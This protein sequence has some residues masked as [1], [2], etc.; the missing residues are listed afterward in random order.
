[1]G[2]SIELER[3]E[4][5]I[6]ANYEKVQK[7][8]DKLAPIFEKSLGHIQ[9]T[10]GKTGG[11]VE[12]DLDMEKPTNRLVKQFENM[13]KRV[14]R[15]S[16]NLDKL[17][18]G[19]GE[20]ATK[21]I[22]AGFAK[23][24]QGAT[25]EIDGIA[26]DIKKKMAQARSQQNKAAYLRTQRDSANKKGDTKNVIKFDSQIANAEAAM[27]KYQNAASKLAGGIKA[28][29]KELPNELDK[30]ANKMD[31]NE[32]QIESMRTRMKQLQDQ[33]QNQR[34]SKGGFDTSKGFEDTPQS[35]KTQEL[36]KKQDSKMAEL[37]TKND[38]LAQAYANAE[39]R[40]KQLQA[41][42]GSLNT[43][44]GKSTIQTGNA[45]MGLK[46]VGKGADESKGLFSKFGGLFNRTSN[47]I[48]HGSRRMSN[49]I[50][51][52][53]RRLSQIAKQVLIFALIAKGIRAMSSGLTSALKTNDQFNASV[54]QIKVNLM[55]A[56]YPIYTAILPA[57]NALTSA[58]AKVTGQA[59]H[60]IATLFGT[61]YSAAKQGAQGLYQNINAMNEAGGSAD[62]N[63]EKV[64][65]LQRSL[66]GFDEINRIGLD[67]NKEEKQ[68]GINFNV[69]DVA[70]P[71]WMGKVQKV[72]QDLFKPFQES[73]AKHGKTVTD[74]WKYALKE[75]GGL[76]QSIGRSFME[77]WTNGTGESVLS[78]ILLIVADIGSTVGNLA[79][80]FN[81]AWN[82][83][84]NGTR[85]MQS[86]FNLVN[87]V[88]ET[89][90]KMTSATAEWAR[91]LDFTPLLESIATLMESLEPLTKNIGD[92]L[93]WF[94]KQVL[95]PIASFTIEEV[96]P[97][98]LDVLSGAI[99]ALN[100]V[101]EA[102]KPLGKWLFD[103]FLVPLAKW[104]GGAIVTVLD[105]VA[106][107]L[108]VIGDW[109]NDHQKAI[110]TFA[111]ILGSFAGAWAV[112]KGVLALGGI[113]STVTTFIG[114]I[115]QLISSVGVLQTAA[116][117]LAP[118]IG[119]I[120][121]P[122]VAVIAVIGG[123]IAAG[124]L[125]W[126]NWDTVK[127]WAGKLGKAIGEKWEGIKKAT[128]EAWGKVTDWTK[129]KW[130]N[131]TT[132][133][134]NAAK[135]S[136][137]WVSDKWGDIKKSTSGAWD[138]VKKTT[139]SLWGDI[140]DGVKSKAETARDKA[141]GAWETMQEKVG[142]FN[143]TIKTTTG[144]AFEEI[145]GWASGLGKKMGEGLAKGFDAVKNGAKE[146]GKGLF[147]FP[148]KAVN[149]VI[150]GVQW[151]LKKVG[152]SKMAADIK[153]FDF[154]YAK[155]TGYHPGGRALVNDGAGSKFREA[156]RLPGG[157]MGL[158][159]NQ[160]NLIVDLPTGSSVLSG[161][162]TASM[163]DGMPAYA[164][165]IGN[166]WGNVKKFTGDVWDYVKN[167]GKLLEAGIS[168]FTDLTGALEPALSIAGGAINTT[169]SAAT[170]FVGEKMKSFFS[171]NDSSISSNG[172]YSFLMDIAN[173]LNSKYGMVT[174]SGFRQ[175]D[176]YDHGKGL[177][178]DIALPGVTQGSPIYRK[179]AD[180]AINMP[181]VKYVI[182]NGMWRHKGKPWVP[183]PDGDHYDHIHISGDM[184]KGG[185]NPDNSSGG[186]SGG[187][188]GWRSQILRA[189]KYMG[190]NATSGQVDGIIKQIYRESSGNEKAIQNSAVWDVNMANGNP[191]RG[192]LQYIPSTFNRYKVA[193]Y[194]NIMRG[195]DQL[196]AFFNNSRW[197][198]DLPYGT[199]GW[200]P[201]GY[202]IRPYAKGTPY[203][204]EDQLAMIHKGEMI[205]PAAFN[206]M[207]PSA[208]FQ[209]LQMP[210]MLREQP[211]DFTYRPRNDQQGFSGGLAGM[212]ESVVQAILDI[213]AQKGGVNNL[214]KTGDI[215]INVGGKE[216]GR[217]A[218]SEINKYHEQVG[219][220]EL[221]L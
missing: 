23:G 220:T 87:I 51:G 173:R 203:L 114:I 154:A 97:S 215:V 47:N 89:I 185:V 11:K 18:K 84:G 183:W 200:G 192:L 128:S 78:N 57:I 73:W 2:T 22:G 134:S 218:V 91:T 49:G 195:F 10:T 43:E 48:A 52:F 41:V 44:L 75:V 30:I 205:V 184:P 24:R 196:M 153:L 79:N 90:R 58:L 181:G 143:E 42:V 214:P 123:L 59:A 54:N 45:A 61:N 40:G 65:K 74:A 175:G 157:Q 50:S 139:S 207:N 166:F 208:N 72:M 168:K 131:V 125:L 132:S 38:D 63:R 26:E 133:V 27:V 64:K 5:V 1:M 62:K 171:A 102:L 152:A 37:I 94:Y 14:E 188:S 35:L 161:P 85:I 80:Q 109:I 217:I 187:A 103:S 15:Q 108:T 169:M 36:I 70:E 100:G 111:V 137:K 186:N 194:G 106:K 115:G 127:E 19:I 6:E 105:G 69:P 71:A 117:F 179:A 7:Q 81:T 12:K 110:E 39:D 99:K 151:V 53:S 210:E 68:P 189:S 167:P 197:R 86:T 206:P 159:P 3:L 174:T 140:S 29:F 150:E 147:E 177:A 136:G 113:I 34:I 148:L 13:T 170:S 204:P 16:D 4:V 138:T 96:I 202:P 141:A 155:G 77:V 162:D 216:F 212:S 119:A 122:I 31:K 156:F 142:G 178:V 198:T 83:A 176:P 209:T 33:Y 120:S 211:R 193:G 191:A 67:K 172:V 21:N 219:R 76:A 60:F 92:G 146:I 182:T 199:R 17:T 165:G 163:F 82:E 124:V 32:G 129:E 116:A 221:N 95:L 93:A 56:F 145:T 126:K 149:G 118:V 112:V 144:K 28:E 130:G 107:A 101:I 55:T 46:K 104:T 20:S 25:K 8:M 98:F 201:T 213:V 158:F 180:D 121:W 135:E 88:L 66:M 190:A 9:K 164:K 160:R